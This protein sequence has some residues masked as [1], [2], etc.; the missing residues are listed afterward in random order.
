[1]TF[2]AKFFLLLVPHRLSPTAAD[3]ILIWDRAVLVKAFVVGL[4]ID[5]AKLLIMVIHE[6]DFKSS[7]TYPF[8]CLIFHLCRNVGVP[9]WNCDTLCT[10]SGIFDIGLI[11]DEDNV[12]APRRGT[13]V[14][15][16]P[17]SENFVNTV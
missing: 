2:T 6:R 5:F 15:L 16:Q 14:E 3:N 12:A 9:I 13:R 17:L 8:A 1:M 4:E 7:T 11:R 10:P